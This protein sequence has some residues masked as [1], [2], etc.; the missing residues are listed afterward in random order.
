[1]L[2]DIDKVFAMLDGKVTP[3]ISLD[4]AFGQHFH[5]LRKGNRISAS[6][7]DLR[8]YP[9]VGTIHFFPTNKK[10]IEQM[11][12]LV[13]NHRRWL[14]PVTEQASSAF[15]E[16]Y[17]HAEKYDKAFLSE[18]KKSFRQSLSY[19]IDPFWAIKY[20]GEEEQLLASE[21]LTKAMASVLS[22]NGINPDELLAD[23]WEACLPLDSQNESE[24]ESLLSLE[25]LTE[26]YVR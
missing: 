20:G 6:Y 19:R 17:D 2:A 12:R 21:I 7:F 11:N 10:L 23:G 3:E 26:I 25:E 1:L 22:Q 15:W 8:Y 16:Q 18:V 24:Q 13:G 5:A 4:K 9:G 14:P